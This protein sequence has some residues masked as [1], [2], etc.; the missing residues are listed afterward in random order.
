MDIYNIT[1]DAFNSYI[2]A[3]IAPYSGANP[4]SD[5]FEVNCKGYWE[6]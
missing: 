3:T 1:K 4:T 6:F 5:P 2:P